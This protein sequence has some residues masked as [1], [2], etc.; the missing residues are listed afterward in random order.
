ME[1]LQQL[2]DSFASLAAAIVAELIM[3]IFGREATDMMSGFV[4]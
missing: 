1:F 4:A 2:L 3:K